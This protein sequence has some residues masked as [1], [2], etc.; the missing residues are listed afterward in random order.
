MSNE[1]SPSTPPKGNASE[2]EEH[3]EL[4]ENEQRTIQRYSTKLDRLI[5][6]CE[7]V[8]TE[9]LDMHATLNVFTKA[10]KMG[11]KRPSPPLS[12]MSDAKPMG[13]PK[14]DAEWTVSEDNQPSPKVKKKGDPQMEHALAG[15]FQQFNPPHS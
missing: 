8:H 12:A 9:V 14:R 5:K 3:E 11:G 15:A 2:Q 10:I 13:A 7:T 1:E 6:I 4:K